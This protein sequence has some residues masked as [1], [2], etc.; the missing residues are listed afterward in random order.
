MRR[1]ERDT[2]RM[3]ARASPYTRA[4][5]CDASLGSSV[6]AEIERLVDLRLRKKLDRRFDEADALLAELGQMGVDVSDDA[7][8]WRADGQS[9]VYAYTRDGGAAG[10]TSGEIAQVEDLMYERGLAKS[11]KDYARSD[12]L[13]DELYELGVDVDDRA[14]TW[15]F[16][17]AR[18][19]GGSPGGVLGGRGGHDYV[20]SRADDYEMSEADLAQ[21]DELLGRRLAAKKARE[22]GRADE[23]QAELRELGVEVDD[24]RREWYVRYHDGRRSASSWNVRPEG[25]RP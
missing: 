21:V 22:F 1:R 6:V 9:F 7:R 19:G 13:L 3:A 17:Y 2:R 20:R 24:K 25:R 12:V 5:D 8:S 23:L 4:P 14:R 15:R 18:G 11:R 16:A 10:R